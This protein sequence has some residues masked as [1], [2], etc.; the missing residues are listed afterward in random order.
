LLN[1]DFLNFL[2]FNLII[3]SLVNFDFLI[4]L[5][6]QNIKISKV[7]FRV[8]FGKRTGTKTENGPYR[9]QNS[10]INTIMSDYIPSWSLGPFDN[11]G[12]PGQVEIDNAVWLP[13]L[14]DSFCQFYRMSPAEMTAFLATEDGKKQVAFDLKAKGWLYEAPVAVVVNKRHGT[15]FVNSTMSALDTTDEQVIRIVWERVYPSLISRSNVVDMM[16]TAEY[17]AGVRSYIIFKLEQA[18]YQFA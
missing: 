11:E 2:T 8:L 16:Q 5:D 17:D 12:F 9:I 10:L 14:T 6:E 18:G 15:Y 4:K 13:W 3:F 7:L 1:V